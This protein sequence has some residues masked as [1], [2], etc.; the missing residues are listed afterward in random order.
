MGS[1][2]PGEVFRLHGD[3]SVSAACRPSGEPGGAARGFSRSIYLASL[4]CDVAPAL[5]RTGTVRRRLGRT[6]RILST[7]HA[8]RHPGLRPRA[9]A[10]AG[11]PRVIR[12]LR[13]SRSRQ[14]RPRAR[15]EALLGVGSAIPGQG[16]PA[17]GTQDHRPKS[18]ERSAIAADVTKPSWLIHVIH[19]RLAPRASGN[20]GSREQARRPDVETRCTAR[21]WRTVAFGPCCVTY[22]AHAGPRPCSE[23]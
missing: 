11:T 9:A 5:A 6:R 1:F 7:G 14:E 18:Y 23:S 8:D 21:R 17:Y 19:R 20:A 2:D 16:S 4:C 15:L 10:G 12:P 22:R 13:L 3:L